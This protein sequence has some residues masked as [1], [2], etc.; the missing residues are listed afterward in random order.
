[1][2]NVI[3]VTGTI[4]DPKLHL[5]DIIN[6]VPNINA[7]SIIRICSDLPTL[8]KDQHVLIIGNDENEVKN[9]DI[10]QIEKIIN[11]KRITFKIPEV[12]DSI[13]NIFDNSLTK[14]RI[15]YNRFIKEQ[16]NYRSRALSKQTTLKRR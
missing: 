10:A 5:N 8:K 4:T 3:I 14:E 16:I 12:L 1:M 9:F 7:Q 13:P 6:I 2:V 15:R 11:Q